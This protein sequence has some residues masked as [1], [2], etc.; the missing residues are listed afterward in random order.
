MTFF[1]NKKLVELLACMRSR[2]IQPVAPAGA[3]LSPP[4]FLR[5]EEFYALGGSAIVSAPANYYVHTKPLSSLF[6]LYFVTLLSSLL[7]SCFFFGGGVFI[8]I[9]IMHN[10][11]PLY[12]TCAA[13][14]HLHACPK[15][16]S[17]EKLR[18][19]ICH[20]IQSLRRQAPYKRSRCPSE[21]TLGIAA[22]CRDSN[23]V[24][25]V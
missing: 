13:P 3:S 22:G 12:M 19:I 9:I 20:M 23:K 5:D 21:P 17:I 7:Q 16:I 24:R 8:P 18:P 2:N 6:L 14:E 10:Y 11:M 15:N 4:L 25:Q 1:N